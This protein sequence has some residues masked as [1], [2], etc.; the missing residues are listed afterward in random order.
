MADYN[1][2]HLVFELQLSTTFVSVVVQRDIFY[3]L[4]DYFI[5]WVFNFDDNEKYVDLANL[6][7]KDIYYANKRNVFIFD[8]DAQ[9]ESEERGELVLKCNWLDIDNTWHYSS[10]K[11][12]GDGVLITL[13]QLKLD[14]E[15]CK[16]YFFYAETPYYEIHPSVKDR[17]FNEERSN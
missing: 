1:D 14:K 8:K 13:D 15:T 17:I 5:I 10:T 2:I 16:P 11:G 7:C 3:R 9:Q 6:M 4:N 12:N